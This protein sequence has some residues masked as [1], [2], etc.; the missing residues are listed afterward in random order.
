MLK[1]NLIIQSSSSGLDIALL[2]DDK[3][4][5]YHQDVA[6]QEYLVGDIYLG[7]VKKILPGLNACFVDIGHEKNAFLHYHDLG[8]SIKNFLGF[9]DHVLKT[10]SQDPDITAYRKIPEIDKNGSLQDVLQPE[11]NIVIQIVKE[12]ISTKGHRVTSQIT[13]A[14]RYFVLI[15]FSSGVAVSKSIRDAQEKKRL[16][17]IFQ[18]RTPVN[19]GVI[20]RTAAE[21]QD[22]RTLEKDFD[23]VLSRWDEIVKSL[24][25][26]KQKL[27]GEVNKAMSLLRDMMNDSFDSIIV[28]TR[29]N[30]TQIQ[31]YLQKI[32]PEKSNIVKL[33]T[34][35][36]PLFEQYRIDKQIKSLFGKIV[37]FGKGSYLIIEHTEAMTVI[38]IN[39]GSKT[40]KDTDREE[41]VLNVNLEAADEVARQLRLRDIGGLIIVDFIDMRSN[42]NQKILLEHMKVAMKRDK[43]KHVCLPLSRFGLMEITRERVR[44]VIDLAFNESCPVC[45][46]TGQVK[47]TILVIDD[48][49]HSLNYIHSELK[50]KFITLY[51]HPFIAAFITK[52]FPS[53]QIRWYLR[54]KSFIQ[55]RPSH[56]MHLID[57]KFLD[58]QGRDILD[59]Y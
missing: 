32:S 46:G 24:S 12:P 22:A 26:N 9:S 18:K 44:P 57:Y 41:N 8:P 15:P 53:R 3:L 33:N 23:S 36:A 47:P 37:N 19:F 16:A 20:I 51:V 38:D 40:A 29:Q 43:T 39:S 56:S 59:E 31:Q 58:R 11:Q 28:D 54:Y 27:L 35:T 34:D 1:R 17:G 42:E 21:N 4:V 14:G 5:E 49:E 10:K 6:N 25:Q 48:I 52:G 50:V 13:L 55:V 7:R 2:E 45:R 30:F